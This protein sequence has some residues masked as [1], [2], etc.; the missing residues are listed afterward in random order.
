MKSVLNNK[1]QIEHFEVKW[2]LQ[3][4]NLNEMCPTC[5]ARGRLEVWR[6]RQGHGGHSKGV[7]LGWGLHRRRVLCWRSEVDLIVKVVLEFLHQAVHKNRLH[8]IHNAT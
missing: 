8:I 3:D 1:F 6:S 5:N 4:M 2:I 7:H